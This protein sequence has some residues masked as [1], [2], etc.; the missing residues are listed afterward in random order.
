MPGIYS[1]DYRREH[2]ALVGDPIVIGMAKGLTDV[3]LKDILHDDGATPRFEFMLA[4][5]R[6][7]QARGG[8]L[9]RSI[10]GVAHALLDL[11]FGVAGR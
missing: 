7:Y 11:R 4:A 5:N 1:D 10:G 6:E 9:S 2:A 8:Q 3:T